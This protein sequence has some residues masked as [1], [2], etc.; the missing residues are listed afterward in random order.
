[1][2]ST[3]K[4]EK[5]NAGVPP[6]KKKVVNQWTGHFDNA[7]GSKDFFDGNGVVGGVNNRLH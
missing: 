4:L 1:M 3:E 2:E 6:A 5:A 7:D